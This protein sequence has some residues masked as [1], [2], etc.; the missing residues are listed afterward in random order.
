MRSRLTVFNQKGGVGKT[1]TALNLGAA[2]A[3]AGQSPVLVDLD[4]QAHLT[5][6]LSPVA[7]GRDS[8]FAYYSDSRPLCEVAR[9]VLLGGLAAELL[10]AHS[11]LNKV[12]TL[13]GKGPGILN[14]LR[15]GLDAAY[16]HGPIEGSLPRPLII[17]CCPMLGVLSL[18]GVCA[19][20]R[21]LIPISTDFLALRGAIQLENTLRAME[22][23]LKQRVQRRYLLTR[24]DS[25]RRMSHDIAAQARQRFGEE[26]CE[27]RI[28]E[29]VAV[30]E[31][32]SCNRDVFSH[33]PDSRGAKDYA[34]LLDELRGSGFWAMN[35]ARAARAG[36][37]A[38]RL[39]AEQRNHVL[40]AHLV[41]LAQCRH[42]VVAAAA[43]QH[44]AMHVHLPE[45]ALGIGFVAA[46][47]VEVVHHEPM[48]GANAESEFDQR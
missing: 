30:A 46:V 20:E 13:F 7:S 32:P 11:E 38:W 36:S 14:R 29:N 10:P 19:S 3:R 9:T 16:G 37:E 43:V 42:A 17:D 22:H 23:V 31:S 1:T 21:V 18:S 5:A 15:A 6:I 41:G 26:L 34:A 2:L 33:A 24:F 25:R 27:T 35:G 4:A 48:A 44:F 28:A 39:L 8:L 45:L 47:N 40:E 12:D